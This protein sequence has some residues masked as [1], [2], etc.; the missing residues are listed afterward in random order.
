MSHHYGEDAVKAS[1]FG[2]RFTIIIQNHETG[3]Q[4]IIEGPVEGVYENYSN[5]KMD[6]SDAMNL[7]NEIAHLLR[8]VL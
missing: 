6:E 5:K 3:A 1:I 4:I 8:R 7:G 2:E